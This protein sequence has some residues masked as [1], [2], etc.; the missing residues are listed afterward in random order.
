V[1]GLEQWAEIRRLSRVERLSNRAIGR[2]LGIHRDTVARALAAAALSK[3]SRAV[4][5]SKLDPFKP[6]LD[7][8]V[9]CVT[10]VAAG[11]GER[12]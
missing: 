9:G 4:R 12:V 7:V 6:S 2:R 5:P 11:I 3:Y 8:S 1:V 10:A